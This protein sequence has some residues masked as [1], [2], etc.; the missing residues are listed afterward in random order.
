M[1]ARWQKLKSRLGTAAVLVF[2]LA[3]GSLVFWNMCGQGPYRDDCRVSLGCRS[4]L[5]LEHALRGEQQVPA[6]GRCTK[7]CSKDDE[8][9]AGHR[10]VVL[11]AAARDDLPPFG[12]PTRACMRVLE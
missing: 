2:M 7:P 11:G 1:G 8:C 5:C 9:G 4:Y 10:C 12:K 3:V 6:S